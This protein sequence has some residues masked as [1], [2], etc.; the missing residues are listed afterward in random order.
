MDALSLKIAEIPALPGCYIFKNKQSEIIY[1]GKSKSLKHR[2]KQYFQNVEAKEGKYSRLTKEIADIEI[3]LTGTETDALILECGLIKIYKPKYNAQLKRRK[4]YPY[5]KIDTSARYPAISLTETEED[6]QEHKDCAYFGCFR[7]KEDAFQTIVLLN[8][9]WQTPM[10][11]KNHFG[12][13]RKACLNYHIRQCC[14]PCENII[15]EEAYNEKISEITQCLNGSPHANA[16]MRR[17]KAAM[18]TAAEELNYEKAAVLRDAIAGLAALMKKQK[19]LNTVLT[20]RDVYLFIRPYNGTAFSLFFI[21]N[22]TSLARV[23][24]DNMEAFHLTALL[25]FVGGIQTQAERFAVDGD[26]GFLTVCLRELH[27]DKLYVPFDKPMRADKIAK[28]LLR[29]YCAEG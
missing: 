4:L 12:G 9:I 6:G 23:N 10:C 7:N 24:F 13:R 8:R 15:S 27:A 26:G 19:K 2:V 29:A 22:G 1:I 25:D 17:L 20:G 3:L 28:K 16:V 5:I 14:A 18:K 21:R 11:G